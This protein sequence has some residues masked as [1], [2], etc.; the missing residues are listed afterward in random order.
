[1]IIVWSPHNYQFYNVSYVNVTR[2]V[3]AD[4]G[5]SWMKRNVPVWYTIFKRLE[6]L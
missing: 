4:V 6:W 3:P 2:F 1:M 5:V